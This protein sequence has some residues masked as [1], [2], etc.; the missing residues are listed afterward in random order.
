MSL[1][2]SCKA[3]CV[4][5][6]EREDWPLPALTWDLG[7]DPS[8]TRA[9]ART[10]SW[11][12]AV[13]GGDWACV[14]PKEELLPEW[15]IRALP[16]QHGPRTQACRKQ[17]PCVVC[18]SWIPGSLRNKETI[19]AYV[20][21]RIY[22]AIMG[23][24]SN[25]P[26]L[27]S[28]LDLWQGQ[29]PAWPVWAPRAYGILGRKDPA[30]ACPGMGPGK[31]QSYVGLSCTQMNAMTCGWSLLGHLTCAYPFALLTFLPLPWEEAASKLR[32]RLCSD[33]FWEGPRTPSLE[34][35]CLRRA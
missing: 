6:T 32:G 15:G 14:G 7:L 26:I 2:D 18:V 23:P 19:L 11:R 31:Y 10:F 22:I 9:A 35:E 30:L 3:E 17:R 21:S 33:A 16:G 29:K 12:G 24:R 27:E 1:M 5:A 25:G 20:G 28:H 34:G 4:V 13:A 8:S